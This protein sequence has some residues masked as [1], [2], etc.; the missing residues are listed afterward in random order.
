M[1]LNPYKF[2]FYTF[3]VSRDHTAED[4]VIKKRDATL[5]RV[6]GRI[7]MGLERQINAIVLYVRYLLNTEQKKTDFKPDDDV[8]A[9]ADITGACRLVS[10]YIAKQG[11]KIKESI[12]G[13]NL[14]AVMTELGNRLYNTILNH[15]RS[16]VYNEPGGMLL[17]TDVKEYTRSIERWEVPSVTKKFDTLPGLINLLVVKPENL[18]QACVASTLADT[19]RNLINSFIQLRQD[20]RGGKRNLAGIFH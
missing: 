16:F 14:I 18:Q 5:Q 17:L 19:D 1:F 11:T 6:E 3:I 7:N 4:E 9:V 8:F 15:I 10:R 20:F 13:S 2:L 12:D